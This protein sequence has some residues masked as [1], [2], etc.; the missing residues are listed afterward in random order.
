MQQ[1]PVLIIGASIAGLAVAASLQKKG[2]DYTIIEK[3]SQTVMPWRNHYER[4]HLHTNKSLSNLPFKKFNKAVPRYPSR[5]QVVDYLDDYR[6]A[7]N[8][9]PQFNTEA[10]TVRKEAT[11]WITETNRGIITS[12]YIIVATGAFGKPRVAEIKGLETFTGPVLHSYGYKT[13]K[14]FSRKDVLVIGFG[15][16]ACEIAIDLYEQGAKPALAVRSAVNVL[17]RDIMGVPILQLSIAMSL[18]P[19]RLA[20]RLNAPLIRLLTG[21]ITKLGLRKLPYGPLEQIKN[22]GHAPV[23]D[24]GTLQLIRGGKIKI[25]GAIDHIHNNMVYFGNGQSASFDVIVT[26][27][28]Y[29]RDYEK[30]IQVDKKRFDDLKYSVRHQQYF[31]MDG[32]YFCGFWIAPTGQMRE[33]ARDA[34]IIAKDICKKEKAR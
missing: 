6:S 27:I 25:H 8:I 13:G 11:R 9:C 32:L 26:A 29:Y 23:L 4:L 16:S 1:T 20:D 7:F 21:D 28:G 31:G 34:Q 30:L 22:D 24:I 14:A 5:Q 3:E 15:N 10:I 33:I 17:P 19:A 12:T 18:L 2:M